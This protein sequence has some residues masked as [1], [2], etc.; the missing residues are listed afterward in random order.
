MSKQHCSAVGH[1]PFVKAAKRELR[2]A[3]T[4]VA[5]V[6]NQSGVQPLLPHFVIGNHS[7]F[8]FKLLRDAQQHQPRNIFLLRETSSWNTKLVMVKI[9]KYLVKC[10]ASVLNLYQPVLFLDVAPCHIHKLVLDAAARVGVWII[11]IPARITYLA[12]PLDTHGFSSFKLWLRKQ[13]QQIR[14]EDGD[15]K[16]VPLEWLKVL[17]QAPRAFFSRRQWHKSFADNGLGTGGSEVREKLNRFANLAEIIPEFPSSAD[18]SYIFPKRRKL[19]Y[20]L[21]ALSK[22]FCQLATSADAQSTSLAVAGAASSSSGLEGAPSS[23]QV[24][25]AVVSQGLARP[26]QTLSIALSSR[27]NARAC[28]QYPVRKSL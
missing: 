13:I 4:Y 11:F 28:R 18:I 24:L 1:A 5:L 12:Q 25:Q 7:R 20:A 15:G 22:P 2:G 27:L 6:C 14:A 17:M 26:D 16:V 19:D 21:P 3:V 9:L 8:T 10:L 23:G